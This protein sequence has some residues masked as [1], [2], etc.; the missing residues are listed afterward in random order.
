[1]RQLLLIVGALWAAPVGAADPGLSKGTP[2]L[3]S[4]TALAFGPDGLLFLGDPQAGQVVVVAT[5][6]TRPAGSQAVN[7]ERLDAKIAAL[8]GVG[9][10]EVRLQDLKVN[11]ASGN[12]YVAVT[13]GTGAGQPALVRV[14]RT[15]EVE[16]V[17]LKEIPFAV[18]KLPDPGKTQR[19]PLGAITCMAFV[20]GRLFVAGLSNEEFASTL[21]IIPFP[22]QQA[23]KG[24][25][26]EIY[27]GSHGRLETNAPIR[28]FTPYRIGD[29]DY[30]IASY[31]C[32]P[33]VKIPVKELKPGAKVRGVTIAEL[34]NR[35]QPL[36][37]IAYSKDGR[38][39][40]LTANTARGVLK[41]PTEEFATAKPITS[42]IT[43]TA[44]V[45]FE[46]IENLQNVV[47]LDK[48][49]DA[50]AIILVRT[51]SGFDLRTIPLP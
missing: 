36:D 10:K 1:M 38:E 7:I 19:E 29:E 30:I 16:A 15:G 49:D 50:R 26:I 2:P 17:P 33:L 6:D 4:I 25:V 13:R 34:G 51:G 37:M 39:Y 24:T 46:K 18:V 43:D 27:H 23:D 47:Q 44:G 31:T 41:I 42:R 40:L 21:R 48:L 11:P 14:L 20:G 9:E 28:T 32:T 45:R 8:L 5:G 35:N 12:V 3:Q 22:F